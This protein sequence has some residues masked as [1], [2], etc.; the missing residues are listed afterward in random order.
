MGQGLQDYLYL[1]Q[2]YQQFI[3][4]FDEHHRQQL[5]LHDDEHGLLEYLHHLHF[6]LD[7]GQGQVLL[8]DAGKGHT[9]HPKFF[10]SSFRKSL[11]ILM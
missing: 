2:H 7:D 10:N 9:P 8:L 6:H 5:L 3:E 1:P 11:N 4:G